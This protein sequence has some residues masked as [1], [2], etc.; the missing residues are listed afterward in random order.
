MIL[1]AG[2]GERMRPLTDDCPKPLLIVGGRPLIEHQIRRLADAGWREIVIN[3][4]WLG[5][6]IRD[7]LG[8]GSG[9]G[10]H[11]QYSE[12]GW[13]ALETGGGIANALPLL[14]ESPFLVVNGDVWCDA[15][16]G[17]LDL[18]EGDLACLLLVDNPTHN[19]EGDFGLRDGRVL[20]DGGERLTFAGIGVY[21][22]ALFAD[23]PGG[24]WPLGPRLRE[25]VA[26]GRVA[27]VRHR[28]DWMDVGTPERL[29]ALDTR[30][31]G[32]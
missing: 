8:D 23:A 13:P 7:A 19:P 3:L 12:E 2:R 16:Y 6:R 18:G 27:G 1:S 4:G 31:A 29:K 11:L 30:L 32:Y 10:V 21:H 25:A 22:P 28:G 17:R 24:A 9:L 15:D 26:A 20:A 14:G 5:D